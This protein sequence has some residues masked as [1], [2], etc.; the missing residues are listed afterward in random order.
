MKFK[1]YLSKFNSKDSNTL[2]DFIVIALY[3]LK[4]GLNIESNDNNE[5]DIFLKQISMNNDRNFLAII[6]LILPYLDDKNNKFNQNNIT[7]FKNAVSELNPDGKAKY[8]NFIFDHNF[9]KKAKFDDKK[10]IKELKINA[11]NQLYSSDEINDTE[12]VYYNSIFYFILDVFNRIRYKF[13]INWINS[14]PLTI[15]TYKD[16]KLYNSSFFYNEETDSIE[17]NNYL[18]IFPNFFEIINDKGEQV[19]NIDK[20]TITG[21]SE[22]EVKK[23]VNS[24][25]TLIKD[26]YGLNLEDIY[27]TIVNDYY[28]SI[29]ANKWLFFEFDN[30]N[31][32]DVLIY[33]LN[34]ILGINTIIDEKSWYMLNT[35]QQA[36]FT[37]NWTKMKEAIEIKKCLFM[38]M[39]L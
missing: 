27:N 24:S 36:T 4:N 29:K 9:I 3:I 20:I 13:Y 15:E 38:I 22:N 8:C 5:L 17:F 28:F 30:G 37:S 23:L 10:N 39:I 11:I 32:I 34:N 6:N 18:L 7:S 31:N 1:Q 26:Y 12:L 2:I 21:S 35:E 19:I 16:S 25:L 33:M 14:F